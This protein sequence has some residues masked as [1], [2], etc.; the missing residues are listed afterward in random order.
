MS[1]PALERRKSS[2]LTD[3]GIRLSYM[4]PA[5]EPVA[6]KVKTPAAVPLKKGPTVP[7]AFSFTEGAPKRRPISMSELPPTPKVGKPSVF[8]VSPASDP[9]S[10]GSVASSAAASEPKVVRRALKSGPGAKKHL[11][12]KAN[13]LLAN[14]KRTNSNNITRNARKSINVNTSAARGN[15]AF[16]RAT[17]GD[18]WTNAEAGFN[19]KPEL[20]ARFMAA[21]NAENRSYGAEKAAL[22]R[23]YMS[24]HSGVVPSSEVDSY[25]KTQLNNLNAQL[26]ARTITS[27]NHIFGK[28]NLDGN[29]LAWASSGLNSSKYDKQK[30][31]IDSAHGTKLQAIK[32]EFFPLIFAA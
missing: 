5:A 30:A 25:Y 11:T 16:M 15:L 6:L 2:V 24:A 3:A 10:L 17:F 7:V 4:P 9:R 18:R 27:T 29:K 1:A 19:S 13:R 31:A 28:L 12:F 26:K 22:L 21:L 14:V 23:R 32:D 20:K 8:G